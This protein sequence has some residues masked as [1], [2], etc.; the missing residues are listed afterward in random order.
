M[1]GDLAATVSNFTN[2]YFDFIFCTKGCIYRWSKSADAASARSDLTFEN[3]TYNRIFGS[4]GA[5]LSA[6][7]EVDT[8]LVFKNEVLHRVT[9]GAYSIAG[10]PGREI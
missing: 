8:R 10:T 6:Y 3:N 7:A 4:D 5:L 9:R 2:N 1:A